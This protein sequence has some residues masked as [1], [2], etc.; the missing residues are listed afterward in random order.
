MQRLDVLPQIVL[1]ASSETTLET[2]LNSFW[3]WLD[4]IVILY[5]IL[6]VLYLYVYLPLKIFIFL[7][8][9]LNIDELKSVWIVHF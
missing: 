1:Y 5:L 9:T 7:R 2:R 6:P 4:K 8:Q 3:I